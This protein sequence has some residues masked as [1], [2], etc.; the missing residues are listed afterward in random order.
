[1]VDITPSRL[2]SLEFTHKLLNERNVAVAP[3][4]VYGPGG[5]GAVRVSLASSDQAL[6]EGLGH[7]CELVRELSARG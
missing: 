7:L 5:E 4:S 6:R 3:G 1:M 2:S